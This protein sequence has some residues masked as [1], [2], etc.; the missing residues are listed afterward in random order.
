MRS[1]ILIGSL[2]LPLYFFLICGVDTFSADE[3]ILDNSSTADWISNSDFRE[4]F[5]GKC[6]LTYILYLSQ[7]VLLFGRQF[8]CSSGMGKLGRKF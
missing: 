1:S 5:W 4:G 8:V 7:F 2:Y 6:E 3:R